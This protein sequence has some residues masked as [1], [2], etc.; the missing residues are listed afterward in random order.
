MYLTYYLKTEKKIDITSHCTVQINN[1]I[2]TL[3]MCYCI[4]TDYLVPSIIHKSLILI[5]DVM[6]F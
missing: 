4:T 6:K 5:I 2:Q 3:K 1:L